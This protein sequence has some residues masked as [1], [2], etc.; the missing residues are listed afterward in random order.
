VFDTLESY[1][2]QSFVSER[3]SVDLK[4]HSQFVSCL[5]SPSF[6]IPKKNGIVRVVSDFRVLNSKVQQVSYSIPR[7]QDILI[8]LNGVTYST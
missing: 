4:M 1:S 7:I 5:Q 6:I 3:K 8:S 2:L